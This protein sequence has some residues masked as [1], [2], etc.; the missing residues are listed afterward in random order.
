MAGLYYEEFFVGQAFE[1]AWTRTVTETDNLL[2][3]A[4]TMNVQPLHIDAH[5]SAGT[6][7]G[8]RLV[9]SIFTLGLVVGIS[10]NDTTIGTT[11]GNLGFGE[12]KF[13]KPVFIGDTLRAKTTILAV[14]ES[15][16]RPEVGIVEFEHTGLNQ[17]DEIVVLCKRQGMM[18]KRPKA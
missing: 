16:S 3:S 11:V 9:N 1:H 17:R 18:R 15:K 2:F 4:L 5:F 6:E 7:I 10:V 13:P 14:R 8:Q 12:T